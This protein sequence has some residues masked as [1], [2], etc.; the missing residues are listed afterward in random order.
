MVAAVPVAHTIPIDQ[1]WREGLYD[2]GDS[3][4][5][6]QS[7]TSATA[8]TDR[9]APP[10][11]SPLEVITQVTPSSAHAAPGTHVR[12]PYHLRAPPTA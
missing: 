2:G 7:V 10:A 9:V 4:D 11:R 12:A 5:V 8:T 1:T 3:D 6:V